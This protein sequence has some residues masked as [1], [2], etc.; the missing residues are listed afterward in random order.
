[1]VCF[2]TPFDSMKILLVLVSTAI[3]LSP[4][5]S[6]AAIPIKFAPGSFCGVVTSAKGS[7]KRIYSVN[8]RKGQRITIKTND[9]AAT[10]VLTNPKNVTSELNGE[11]NFSFTAN[12]SGNY[13]L[14][15]YEGD[16]E[17]YTPDLTVCV[18]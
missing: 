17:S 1:M 12:Y 13:T 7:T 9:P 10:L 6:F 5:A 4:I 3:A 16:S 11:R 2:N 14:R 18:K 15:F 8:V